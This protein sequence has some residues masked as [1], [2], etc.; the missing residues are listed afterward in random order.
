MYLPADPLTVKCDECEAAPGVSCRTN[1]GTEAIHLDRQRLTDLRSL[2]RGT[3][4]LCGQWMVRGSVL[5]STADAWHPD[6]TD[7]DACPVLPDARTDWNA[8]A[9]AVNLGLRPGYPGLE[10]FRPD[11]DPASVCPECRQGKCANCT[12]TVP[13]GDGPQVLPCPCGTA[14]HPASAGTPQ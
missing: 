13:V 7:A 10:H 8:Y 3:C 11:L 12:F 9:T 14:G 5:G 4:G 6:T 1:Y 2:E